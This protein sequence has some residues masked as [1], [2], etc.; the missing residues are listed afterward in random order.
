MNTLTKG[1]VGYG[2]RKTDWKF[3]PN[4]KEVGSWC[5]ILWS[6]MEDSAN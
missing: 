3:L 4:L 1:R 5:P 6:S 2:G